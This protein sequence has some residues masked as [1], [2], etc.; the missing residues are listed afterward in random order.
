MGTVIQMFGRSA[1]T[2]SP[3]ATS[4]F[5]RREEMR[6]DAVMASLDALLATADVPGR[7]TL[8]L[9]RG[10]GGALRVTATIGAGSPL[11]M[12]SSY[13]AGRLDDFAGIVRTAINGWRTMLQSRLDMRLI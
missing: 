5:C 3:V 1:A 2:A 12:T 10:D 6:R 4:A 7:L 8:R 11:A 9:Q 13:P